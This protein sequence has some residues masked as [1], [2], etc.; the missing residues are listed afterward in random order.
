M[1]ETVILTLDE[2]QALCHEWQ[3]VLGLRD[4][5]IDVV[6]WRGY[7]MGKNQGH[8]SWNFA[9]RQTR[10][11]LLDPGDYPK[12]VIRPYDMERT[13]VHELLHVVFTQVDGTKGITGLLFEQGLDAVVAGLMTLKRGR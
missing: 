8:V 6:F 10:V 3:E 4:W 7:D 2:L 5:D 9:A 12:D 13:L 1:S 11:S